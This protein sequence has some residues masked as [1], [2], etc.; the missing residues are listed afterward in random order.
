MSEP[1]QVEATLHQAKTMA[2]GGTNVTFD[3]QEMNPERLAALFSM[4]GQLGWLAFASRGTEVVVPDNPPK[5]FKTDKSNAQRVRA[6]LFILWK[7]LGADGE[8]Q[9]FYDRKTETMLEW[10]SEKIDEA[11][12]RS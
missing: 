6:R 9:A 4:K 8:F 7:A 10:I 1:F 11:K 12:G 5:E 3:C 2:D